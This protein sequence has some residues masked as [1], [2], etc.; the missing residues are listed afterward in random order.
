LFNVSTRLIPA[1]GR[2]AADMQPD[3]DDAEPNSRGLGPGS[4]TGRVAGSSPATTV[5]KRLPAG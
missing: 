1:E 5:P 4:Q 2:Q 3:S